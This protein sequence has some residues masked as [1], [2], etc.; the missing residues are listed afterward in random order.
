MYAFFFVVVLQERNKDFNQLLSTMKEL[1][2]HRCKVLSGQLP[3]DELR[4]LKHR[5]TQAIDRINA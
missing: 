1:I 5:I 4:Q 3:T 2:L